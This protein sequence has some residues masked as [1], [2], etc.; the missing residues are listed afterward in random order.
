MARRVSF[1]EELA[2]LSAVAAAPR[3]DDARARLLAGLG[4]KRSLVA[5]RAARLVKEHAVA[6]LERELAGTFARFLVDP[7][8]SDPVCQAK[9]AA[10][11]ALDYGESA[12]A[13][14]FLR[15]ARHVQ[16]E[17]GTDTAA[18]LRARAV[19]ALA[20]LGHPDFDLVAAALLADAI[21]NV[22]QA[23]LDALAHRGDRAGA[24]L[25]LLRLTAGDDDP[26][27]LLAAMT[28]LLQLAP[29]WALPLLGEALDGDDERRVELAAVALG[30]SRDDD[31]LALLLAALS[32]RTRSP[33]REPIIRG[34]GLH[35]SDRALATILEIVANGAPDDART[36][37]E[38][39]APRRFEPTITTRVRA[40]AAQNDRADLTPF[41]DDAFR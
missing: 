37:I 17:G 25:A 26:A 22:R 19:L 4:S 1:E 24:A 10:L 36:A 21:A 38:S 39:L 23:A 11:E 16:F 32:R 27:V 29:A 33:E 15:A 40:A 5:A 30:Q 18:P 20:R 34:I 8:K 14:P 3:S 6:G 9:L 7:V 13:E 41:I 28:T 31:A 12:D 35:R 2:A